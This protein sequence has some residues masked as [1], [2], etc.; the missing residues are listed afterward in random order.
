MKLPSLALVF[1]AALSPITDAAE[2]PQLT[3]VTKKAG[4]TWRH[5]IGDDALTNIVESTGAGCVFLDFDGD[6]DLDIYLVNGSYHP[7]FSHAR[8]RN[9][10]GK[11][12]NA[13]YRNDGDGTFTDVTEAAGIGDRGYGMAAVA[14]DYDNDGDTDLFVT[15]YGRD[16]L[17]KNNGDGSFS[18][19]TDSAGV[20]D[21]RWTVGATFFDF[22]RD[23]LL[24]LYVGAYLLFDPDYRHYF[25]ADGFPGPLSYPGRRD[26]LY[27]N[28]GDGTFENVSKTAG[29]D[30]PDGRAMG[31]AACDID[32]DGDEDIFVANDGMENYLWRNKGDGRFEN[33]ALATG[34]AFG[35][36]GEATSAMGPEFG[37]F[38]LDG[39]VDLFVPDMGYGCLYRNTGKGWF[40]EKSAR[41][42]VAAVLGQYVSWSGNFL[43]IDNDGWLDIFVVNG[44]AHHLEAEEDTLFLNRKGAEFEDISAKTGVA[45]STKFVGRGS[46]SGDFDNDGDLDLL[47][48]NLNDRP[49]LL[50]NDLDNQHHWLELRLIGT[51]SNRDAIGARVRL[52]AG[53][54]TQLRDVRTSSGYLSQSDPRLHFGL[55]S[56]TVADHIEISWP[57]GT[58]QNLRK[59]AADQLLTITEP[60]PTE[61]TE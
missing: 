50:R 42:G 41:L 32:G 27:R 5:S 23:G 16:T 56:S 46:A 20:G 1:V 17:F 14:A 21:E 2:T 33:T 38:D 22:D 24:D 34:T 59:I 48:L 15:N 52:T 10:A 4:I 49:R 28:R 44:D 47:V 26:T 58:V 7:D 36:N 60:E 29:I 8:G 55:G 51:T 54:H 35:Q 39:L 9:L 18:D 25:A 19:V 30:N 3:D 37:D 45:L 13:L 11:L 40:E 12:A 31:I 6:G 53:G 61:K 43:D 57:S